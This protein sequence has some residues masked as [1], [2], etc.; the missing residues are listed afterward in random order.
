MQLL[1]FLMKQLYDWS[2]EPNYNYVLDI[3]RSVSYK[4]VRMSMYVLIIQLWNW[5]RTKESILFTVNVMFKISYGIT[6][7][8]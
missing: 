8:T 6:C 7:Q 1:F 2:D 4:A 5:Y 3:Y